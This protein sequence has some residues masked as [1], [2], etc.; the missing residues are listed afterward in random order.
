[1]VNY[2]ILKTQLLKKS[3]QQPPT[4]YFF[5][6]LD[7][8]MTYGKNKRLNL[9]PQTAPTATQ[10][11][12]KQHLLKEGGLAWLP[13]SV[14][15]GGFQPH[16]HFHS[17]ESWIFCRV[18]KTSAG[19]TV[20]KSRA[21]TV[22]QGTNIP[23][24]AVI[25]FC[26]L[27]LMFSFLTH[28]GNRKVIAGIASGAELRSP[29]HIFTLSQ[30]R[31][32]AFSL[33]PHCWGYLKNK[34]AYK[35]K[36]QYFSQRRMVPWGGEKILY[37]QSIHMSRPKWVRSP[38]CGVAPGKLGSSGRLLLSAVLFMLTCFKKITTSF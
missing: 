28:H 27:P 20:A 9:C 22:C 17:L 7:I 18:C 5:I 34:S 30:Q 8:L 21:T 33:C 26:A 4:Y 16:V 2:N 25:V 10:S 35:R 31:A 13:A 37:R 1:M 32:A 11:W 38:W 14:R 12:N 36:P 3:F 23:A 19:K 15:R 6:I 24:L 29:I